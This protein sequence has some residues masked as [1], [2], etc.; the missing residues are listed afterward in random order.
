MFLCKYE[1]IALY[2]ESLSFM[3]FFV[4][5]GRHKKDDFLC[6]I[7]PSMDCTFEK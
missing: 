3:T 4:Y 7:F 6:L 1:A 5:M 2:S